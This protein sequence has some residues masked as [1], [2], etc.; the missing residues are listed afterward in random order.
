M[1][2]RILIALCFILLISAVL[3]F[4]PYNIF[5]HLTAEEKVTSIFNDP[6]LREV[7]FG[8]DSEITNVKYLGKYIYQVETEENTYLVKIKSSSSAHSIEVYEHNLH[9]T[10]NRNY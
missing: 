5:H 10:Q 1:K 3:L 4:Y 7:T 2:K 9:V 6:N 8:D